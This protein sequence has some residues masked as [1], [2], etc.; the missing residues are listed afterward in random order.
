MISVGDQLDPRIVTNLDGRSVPIPDPS[1]RLHLQFRRHAGCPICNTHL[2]SVTQRLDEIKAVGIREMVF[3]HSTPELLRQYQQAL[4]YDVIPDP[5]RHVYRD[6]GV[7]RSWRSILTPKV[8]ASVGAGLVQQRA[9]GALGTLTES[10]LGM[11]ADFLVDTDGTVLAA[12]YGEHG[13]D[14]WSVDELLALAG[15]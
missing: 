14:Q 1:H 7:E 4:P 11:P 10:H 2:R 9:K 8:L 5:E 12:K 15:A 13:A 3:F 6:F